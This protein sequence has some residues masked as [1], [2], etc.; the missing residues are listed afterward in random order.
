MTAHQVIIVQI[1]SLAF[2][3]SGK[4]LLVRAC[5]CAFMCRSVSGCALSLFLVFDVQFAD[6][7]LSL[8]LSLFLSFSLCAV[9][10]IVLLD[11]IVAAEASSCRII[12]KTI[13]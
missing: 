2:G 3:R 13:S 12:A 1:L 4:L 9:V 7:S 6:L 8:F 5:A 10:N 11:Q